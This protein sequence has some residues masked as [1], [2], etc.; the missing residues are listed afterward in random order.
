MEG[1]KN[2]KKHPHL[3]HA[4]GSV[5][6]LGFLR[7]LFLYATRLQQ[8]LTIIPGHKAGTWFLRQVAYALKITTD[9]HDHAFMFCHQVF[10]EIA[11]AVHA[12]LLVQRAFHALKVLDD[13]LMAFDQVI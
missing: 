5:L 6:V 7:V 8:R 12:V 2:T 10:Q 13:D 9:Q 1:N 4:S 3:L 11:R